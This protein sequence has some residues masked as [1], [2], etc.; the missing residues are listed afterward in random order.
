[1]KWLAMTML[2][3]MAAAGEA[4]ADWQVY[5]EGKTVIAAVDYLSYAPYHNQ[6][7]VW[8]RWHYVKPRQGVA[9]RKIQFTADC[10]AHRLFE[11][12]DATYNTAGDFIAT[13]KY[14]QAP[15]EF[16]IKPGSLNEA[17][18]ELLCK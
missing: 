1:M 10:T 4:V 11:I 16:P 6:P 7:S 15:R 5:R 13:S 2:I 8:V 14:Y 17:T 9:G 12:A 18:F 3:I